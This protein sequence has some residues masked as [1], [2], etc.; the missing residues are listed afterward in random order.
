MSLDVIN[1]PAPHALIGTVHSSTPS[2]SSQSL[3]HHYHFHAHVTSSVPLSDFACRLQQLLVTRACS[4]VHPLNLTIPFFVLD[5]SSS[6]RWVASKLSFHRVGAFDFTLSL[7]F[8]GL[9]RLSLDIKIHASRALL[10]LTMRLW[11]HFLV[12]DVTFCRLPHSRSHLSH[13]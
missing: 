4:A 5:C 6:E 13:G 9:L 7:K 3:A 12:F 8:T 11:R 10:G 1:M 2:L